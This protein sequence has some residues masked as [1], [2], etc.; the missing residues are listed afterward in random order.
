MYY[1]IWKCHRGKTECCA[2]CSLR[3]EGKCKNPTCSLTN[4][5]DCP[6]L[7]KTEGEAYIRRLMLEMEA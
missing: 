1:C 3:K 4:P 7:C 5:K 2:Y 6:Y